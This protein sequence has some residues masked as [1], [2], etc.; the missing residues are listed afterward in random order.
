M[1]DRNPANRTFLVIVNDSNKS[2]DELKWA[3][4]NCVTN[5]Y[6]SEMAFNFGDP[7]EREPR[8]TMVEVPDGF[9]VDVPARTVRPMP[10]DPTMYGYDQI[11]IKYKT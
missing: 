8:V 3:L 6:G 10:D 11:R 1:I 5:G 7:Y 4:F 2:L 9:D